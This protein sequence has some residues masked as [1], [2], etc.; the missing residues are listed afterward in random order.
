TPHIRHERVSR[1]NLTACPHIGLTQIL[2]LPYHVD[3]L[4]LHS[5]PTR[6]SSDLHRREIRLLLRVRELRNRDRGQNADDHD[7]DQK[8]DQ[9]KSE[10]HTPDLQPRFVLLCGRLSLPSMYSSLPERHESYSAWPSY[11]KHRRS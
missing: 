3:D 8:L 7:D 2:R 5:F 9:C 4:D 11:I 1:T 10:A 6:R